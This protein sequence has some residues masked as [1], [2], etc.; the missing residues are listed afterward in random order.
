MSR[1]VRRPT[2]KEDMSLAR[3]GKI[4]LADGN[5]QT[6]GYKKAYEIIN[7]RESTNFYNSPQID[8]DIVWKRKAEDIPEPV[9]EKE[10]EEDQDDEHEPA[11]L[12]EESDGV[13]SEGTAEPGQSGFVRGAVDVRRTKLKPGQ[14]KPWK[15]K[16]GAET[17][18]A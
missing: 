6:V 16:P 11:G 13:Q 4:R 8:S 15:R 17:D 2:L 3:S 9:E 5:I 1:E 12:S 10:L 14:P 18:T 7:E